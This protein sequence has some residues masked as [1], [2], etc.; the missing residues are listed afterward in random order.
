MTSCDIVLL[1]SYE[2]HITTFKYCIDVWCKSF[3]HTPQNF[4][5]L[6][7]EYVLEVAAILVSTC[8]KIIQK[9]AYE[10][11]TVDKTAPQQLFVN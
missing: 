7:I 1:E 5:I 3:T 8:I 6:R 2:L 11:T 10:Y 9:N 4:K